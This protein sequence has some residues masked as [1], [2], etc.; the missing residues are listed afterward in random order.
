MQNLY[1]KLVKFLIKH[2]FLAQDS[3]SNQLTL[4]NLKEDSGVT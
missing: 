1:P 2:T 3:G 4:G